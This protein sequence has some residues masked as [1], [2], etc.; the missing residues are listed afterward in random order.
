MRVKHPKKAISNSQDC[1]TP[2][3]GL[4]ITFMNI[5]HVCY[6][7]VFTLLSCS[8]WIYLDTHTQTYKKHYKHRSSVFFGVGSPLAASTA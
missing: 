7:P 5:Q 2:S 6:Y 1:K 3:S 4:S 8:P